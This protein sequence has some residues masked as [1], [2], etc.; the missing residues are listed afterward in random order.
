MNAGEEKEEVRG[1]GRV[2]VPRG[3]RQ[4]GRERERGRGETERRK[5]ESV[6]VGG[7]WSATL[8]HAVYR[9]LPSLYMWSV[10]SPF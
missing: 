10:C 9:P 7:T 2:E 8:S 4:R 5:E 1:G 6:M 3:G